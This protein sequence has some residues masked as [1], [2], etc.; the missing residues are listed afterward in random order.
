[1]KNKKVKEYLYHLQGLNIIRTFAA[2]NRGH[3]ADLLLMITAFEPPS[4]TN[5]KRVLPVSQYAEL[6]SLYIDSMKLRRKFMQEAKGNPRMQKALAVAIRIKACIKRDSIIR[7]WSINKVHKL[8]GISAKTLNCYIPI[9]K[10]MGIITYSGKQNQHLVIGKLASHSAYRNICIDKFDFSSYRSIYNSLRAFLVLSI[11][12]RKDF[13]KRT[14]QIAT[15]PQK[16]D[17]FMAARRT[18]KRLVKQGI[19]RC[20]NGKYKENGISYKRIAKETGNCI[21]T[22]ENIIKYAV[23]LGWVKKVKNYIQMF[24]YRVVGRCIDGYTFTTKNN[25]YIVYSNSYIL[26]KSVSQDLGLVGDILDSKK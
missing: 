19:V 21:R 7:D 6:F 26:S 10:E 12:H 1:M 17:N 3:F 13:V 20:V 2:A 4:Y 11:Q 5:L 14:I 15:N 9:L 18:M 8:S 23:S 16:G 24:M 22:A 25:G